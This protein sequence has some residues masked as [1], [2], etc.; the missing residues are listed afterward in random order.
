MIIPQADRNLRGGRPSIGRVL[1]PFIYKDWLISAQ[2]P[3]LLEY[4]FRWVRGM[5]SSGWVVP[6]HDAGFGLFE[7]PAGGLLI[8]VVVTAGCAEVAFA[9]WSVRPWNGV[10][11]VGVGGGPVAAGRGALTRA[12]LDQVLDLPADHVLIRVMPVIT[13]PLGDRGERDSQPAQ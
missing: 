1:R 10:V 3:P 5:G 4:V 8:P 7:A 9:G 2:A 12:G 6:F 13:L 11:G